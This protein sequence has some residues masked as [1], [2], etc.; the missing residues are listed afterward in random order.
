MARGNRHLCYHVTQAFPKVVVGGIYAW[1]YLLVVSTSRVIW[2]GTA[3]LALVTAVVAVSLYCYVLTLQLGPGYVADVPELSLDASPD[4]P[5]ANIAVHA[6]TLKV[7]GSFR[8]CGRC[9]VWKPD[10]AHHCRLC[11]ECVLRMD[12]HCPWFGICIGNHNLRVFVQFVGWTV[13][14]C[15][16]VAPCGWDAVKR[17]VYGAVEVGDGVFINWMILTVIAIVMGIALAVFM[18]F[19]VYQLVNNVSTIESYDFNH[20]RGRRGGTDPG[21]VNIWDIGRRRNVEAYMGGSWWQWCVP[22]AVGHGDGLQ[23]PVNGAALEQLERGVQDVRALNSRVE[24]WR[25][26]ERAREEANLRNGLLV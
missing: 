25:S 8:V 26:V 12:H 22:V 10:R 6:H 13:V 24:E 9:R 15:A 7:D 4:A 1:S 2:A 23:F 17:Y 3:R 19:T 16:V 18:G 5:P 20:V 11:D 21:N 14:Y